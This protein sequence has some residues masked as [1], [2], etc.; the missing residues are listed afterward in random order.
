MKHLLDV[1]ALIACEHQGSPHHATFHAWAKREGMASLATCGLTELGFI[2]VS[3]LAF[4]YSL[5]EAETSL[6]AIKSRLGGYLVDAPSPLLPA[7]AS[8]A[9]KTSDGYLVQ[10]AETHGLKLATF[11][12]DI[13]GVAPIR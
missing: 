11:D 1:N 5:T 13:P 6:I 12:T 9:A 2:R 4:G 3:M 8:T 10:I 7:W